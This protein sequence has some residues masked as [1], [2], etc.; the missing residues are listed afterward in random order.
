MAA[1]VSPTHLLGPDVL[2][3]A[4]SSL[5]RLPVSQASPRPCP[6]ALI[7][8]AAGCLICSQ[9]LS[10]LK[11]LSPSVFLPLLFPFH[12]CDS[13]FCKLEKYNW[14]VGMPRSGELRIYGWQLKFYE[15]QLRLVIE[16]FECD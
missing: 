16:L 2:P 1:L 4:L 15:L 3:S 12:L 10:L 6:S 7:P 13:L 14:V 5:P 8:P 9:Q 11:A